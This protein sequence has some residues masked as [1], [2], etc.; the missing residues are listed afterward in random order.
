MRK[1]LTLAFVCAIAITAFSAPHAYAKKCKGS[2]GNRIWE[3]RNQDGIQQPDEP[4]I[5]N[6]RVWLYQGNK[7]YETWTDE[8]GYY[9]FKTI[10]EGSYVVTVKTEDVGKRYQSYDPD[11]R[12]DNRTR[13]WIDGD[14]DKHTKADFAY[15]YGYAPNTGAG[16]YAAMGAAG[17]AGLTTLFAL[18][19]RTKRADA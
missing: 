7:H 14:H 19:R 4:G 10:C 13:V 2:I 8:N 9:K 5:P 11:G 6:V 17:A 12:Y 1:V 16:L 15:I 18:R 3:D